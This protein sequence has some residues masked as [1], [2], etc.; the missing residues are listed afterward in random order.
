MKLTIQMP[1]STS[2]MPR[3][4]TRFAKGHKATCVA[5]FASIVANRPGATLDPEIAQRLLDELA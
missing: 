4:T 1:S 5:S 3:R 2:L